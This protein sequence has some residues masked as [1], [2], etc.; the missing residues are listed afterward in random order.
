M[1]LK[2]L[3]GLSYEYTISSILTEAIIGPYVFS[4]DFY[5]VHIHILL[6]VSFTVQSSNLAVYFANKDFGGGGG[7]FVIIPAQCK[8]HNCNT[9]ICFT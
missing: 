6:L 7:V 2:H 5:T 8:M 1:C 4:Y 9:G 3:S